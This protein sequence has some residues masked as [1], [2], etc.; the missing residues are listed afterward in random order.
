MDNKDEIE[1]HNTDT[2][3]D[4]D[5]K[6]EY[7]N[8]DGESI[9]KVIPDTTIIGYAQREDEN[10]EFR[11]YKSAT[12]ITGT[13]SSSVQVKKEEN[14]MTYSK[15]SPTEPNNLRDKGYTSSMQGSGSVQTKRDGNT[16]T[17][18]V[19]SSSN[20]TQEIDHKL[21]EVNQRINDVDTRLASEKPFT[22][23]TDPESGEKVYKK[24]DQYQSLTKE[25]EQ[26]SREKEEIESVKSVLST[27]TSEG[28]EGTA[29]VIT[30]SRTSIAT[31]T[32]QSGTTTT[33]RETTT[34]TN[35]QSEI[36]EV[37]RELDSINAKLD[38]TPKDRTYKDPETGKTVHHESTE[39]RSYQDQKS[40]LE[41]KKETLLEQQNQEQTTQPSNISSKGYPSSTSGTTTSSKTST[42]SNQSELDQVNRELDE[43]DAKLESTP[44]DRTYKDP[45]TGKTVR[46]AST[47]YKTY[48]ERKN[49]LEAR[50][51]S[52]TEQQSTESVNLSDKGYPSSTSGTTA[53]TKTST[54]S[55]QSELDQVN[56]ELD[57]INAKLDSTPRITRY[58]DKDTGE[59][60]TK[61][62]T[63]YKSYQARKSELESK[64]ETLFEQQKQEQTTE[65][66][67]LSSKGYPSST[68]TTS[69]KPTTATSNNQAKLDEVN[70]ELDEIE[71]KLETT[72][73]VT[74]YY[75]K[76]TGEWVTKESTEYKTYQARKNELEAKKASL[77]E[78]QTTEPG[79]LSS[80][81]YPS[82][83]DVTSKPTLSKIDNQ[84][85]LDEVN[86]ELDELEAKLK[87][88][89]KMTR[90][91]DK[92]TGEWVYKESEEYKLYLKQK[93]DLESQKTSLTEKINLETQQTTEPA[94]EHSN[95][96][97][98]SA[99][100]KMD[101]IPQKIAITNENGER[102]YIDNP[103][104]IN[105]KKE[106]EK[107]LLQDVKT[108]TTAT[109]TTTATVGSFVTIPSNID[110]LLDKYYSEN[111][112]GGGYDSKV[113]ELIT[114]LKLSI[115][116]YHSKTESMFTNKT[117]RKFSGLASKQ[118]EKLY[119]YVDSENQAIIDYLSDTLYGVSSE[120]SKL[121]TLLEQR[122]EIKKQIEEKEKELE[123]YQTNLSA[124]TKKLSSAK[125]AARKYNKERLVA[126]Q[127]EEVVDNSLSTKESNNKRLIATL[128]NNISNINTTITEIENELETLNE[129][130]DSV[131]E[132]AYICLSKIQEYENMKIS[133]KT[134][135]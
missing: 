53:T 132:E 111:I 103:A 60:V 128:N 10:G 89:P 46:V 47:E 122:E 26:L 114:T 123:E 105:A 27:P 23:Y 29:N 126:D 82:S 90:Y 31:N 2:F 36:D 125:S 124:E 104:Y 117:Q 62:S 64:K 65:P 19:S 91:Y 30:K 99:K 16:V 12:P 83:T 113:T 81:G 5:Y 33:V 74:R 95:Y 35:N 15:S 70:R 56:R 55:N 21:E 11:A 67:N 50:K 97:L 85:E 76:D 22:T 42:S 80:K 96:Q 78:Q 66:A 17:T 94:I 86:K 7:F 8:N 59:W 58:Y 108:G 41:S 88:T 101:S 45:E 69:A 131:N 3:V 63:E 75:D 135:A 34:M 107:L 129:S 109:Y 32:K 72:P 40:A 112:L 110:E 115:S 4:E 20:D 14:G 77:T 6:V 68:D 38:S 49:E 92:D 134:F 106:Y 73:K 51:T 61:E 71:S 39:Y 102:E 118:L 127:N 25:K 119:D 84:T 44:K 120:V 24:S 54:S 9:G 79:N 130:K 1:I 116:E 18:T 87:S 100:A 121:S 98:E 133:F 37:N 52:L 93:A 57:S 13:G 28:K 48:Q 43:I